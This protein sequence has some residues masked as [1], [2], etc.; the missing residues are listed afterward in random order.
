MYTVT[1]IYRPAKLKEGV[2][3]AVVVVVEGAPKADDPP[4]REDD[5]LDG[6]VV[7]NA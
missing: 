4:N 3:V 6:A 7:A 5:V 1:N 2:V